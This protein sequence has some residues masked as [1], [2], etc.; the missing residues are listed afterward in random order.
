M[1]VVRLELTLQETNQILEALGQMPFARVYQLVN[2]IQQQAS[3]QIEERQEEQ[4]SS[5]G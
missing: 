1:K 2:K 3:E 5:E 4:D